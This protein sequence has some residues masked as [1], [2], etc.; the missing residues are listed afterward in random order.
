[1]YTAFMCHYLNLLR[2]YHGWKAWKTDLKND[3]LEFLWE[4]AGNEIQKLNPQ[5]PVTLFLGHEQPIK[6]IVNWTS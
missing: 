2:D 3:Y 6:V 4:F 5:D 1:M